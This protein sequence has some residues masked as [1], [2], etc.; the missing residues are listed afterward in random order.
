MAYG[1]RF[2]AEA[3][4]YDIGHVEHVLAT[5]E[6]VVDLYRHRTDQ[7]QFHCKIIHAGP[8]VPVSTRV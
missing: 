4:M 5:G 8:A 3:A 7:R 1:E 2:S 6:L